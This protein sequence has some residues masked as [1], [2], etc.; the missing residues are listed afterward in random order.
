MEELLVVFGDL[1][2][3]FLPENR[4]LRRLVYLGALVG[5]GALVWL[6]VGVL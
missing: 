2:S 4:W 5:F 3:A 6:I 1:V